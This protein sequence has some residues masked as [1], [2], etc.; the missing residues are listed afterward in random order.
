MKLFWLYLIWILVHKHATTMAGWKETVIEKVRGKD[1]AGYLLYSI[2]WMTHYLYTGFY[3][4]IMVYGE[5]IA[6]SHNQENRKIELVWIA[7]HGFLPSRTKRSLLQIE[8]LW[9]LCLS[10]KSKIIWDVWVKERRHINYNLGCENSERGWVK[11]WALILV[12]FLTM[13]RGTSRIFT[14][15]TSAGS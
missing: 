14:T 1:I 2:R 3:K 10:I 15:L 4:L 7:I 9:W 12:F 11:L 8:I 13:N 5:V 6:V